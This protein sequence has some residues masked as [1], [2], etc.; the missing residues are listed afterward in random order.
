MTYTSGSDVDVAIKGNGLVFDDVVEASAE[1][2]KYMLH[3][4][5]D[6]VIYDRISER[7]LV[8]H[9]DRV[10]IILFDRKNL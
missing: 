5:L 4:K 9:I 3:Y 10:G 8:E 2:E 6:I 7:A 1:I